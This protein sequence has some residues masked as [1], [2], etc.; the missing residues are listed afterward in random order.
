[1]IDVR[2]LKIIKSNFPIMIADKAISKSICRNF[3]KEIQV[4]KVFDDM[5]MGGRSRINK[6]SKNFKNFIKNSK[7]A[8]KLYKQFNNFNFYNKI[9]N[10]F[11]KKFKDNSWSSVNQ[12]Y[13]FQKRKFTPKKKYNSNELKK[14]LGINNKKSTINLDIDFSVSKGGYRLRP[15]RDDITRQYNFLIYLNDIP[16]LNGGSLTIYKKKT[17]KK[18][19]KSFQR[20][21]KINELSI[22]KEFTPKTG[23]VIFFQ[24]T[25]NSYHGVKRFVEHKS[26]K[27]YFIYG[28]YAFNVP[29]VWQ[30]QNINYHPTIKFTKKK[31]L[32][33]F[34]ESNYT[35]RKAS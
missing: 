26:Q 16:K 23:S 13:K 31:M 10:I 20:F 12:A 7:N 32:S 29:I 27:R 35:V 33:S 34:H 22:V 9:E 15:H 24:S 3:V 14:I 4:S 30:F 2:K 17:D 19:R 8:A 5:I 28:S 6:G 25:P 21:P 18:I 11:K 1:M